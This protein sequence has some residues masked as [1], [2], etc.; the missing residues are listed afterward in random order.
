ML[1]K[2]IREGERYPRGYGLAWF[3]VTMLQGVCYPVPLNWVVW[4]WRGIMDALREPPLDPRILDGL[5]G[6]RKVDGLMREIDKLHQRLKDHDNRR[7][8]LEN[9]IR[10][11]HEV[12]LGRMRTGGLHSP[13]VDEVQ[14]LRD[15]YDAAVEL[16]TRINATLDEHE[17]ERVGL[18]KA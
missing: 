14:V 6:L 2:R 16:L 12:A 15:R 18:P 9:D 5:Y 10:L 13:A 17:R 8:V 11:A 1:A 4:V 3:D 7:A